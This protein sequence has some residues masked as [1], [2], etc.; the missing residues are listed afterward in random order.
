MSHCTGEI[1]C[2]KRAT[3]KDFLYDGS[4]QQ[5]VGSILAMAQCFALMPVVGVKSAKALNLKFQWTSFRTIYSFIIFLLTSVYAGMT[6]WI[7]FNNPIQLD[8]MSE[9]HHF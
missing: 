5:A 8:R 4:F 2:L 3:R 9:L 7:T 6:F 1:K